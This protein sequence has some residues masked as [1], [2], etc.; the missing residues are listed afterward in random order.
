MGKPALVGG[1]S[2]SLS[3]PLSSIGISAGGHSLPP[4]ALFPHAFYSRQL[5]TLTDVVLRVGAEEIACHRNVL[6]AVS[7]FFNAMFTNGAFSS[8]ER[9][10]KGGVR[11][12]GQR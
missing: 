5:G 11:A 1:N 4:L 6:A 8:A 10:G 7:P 2:L 12:G 9:K 3:L